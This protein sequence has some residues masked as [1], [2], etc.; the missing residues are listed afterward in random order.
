MDDDFNTADAI[1]RSSSS[2]SSPTPQSPGQA[3]RNMFPG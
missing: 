1:S 3:Q 2:S